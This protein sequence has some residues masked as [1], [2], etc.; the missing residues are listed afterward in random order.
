MMQSLNPVQEWEQRR[1]EANRYYQGGKFQDYLDLV[2]KNLQLARAIPDRVRE[3]Y[4]LNDLG[5][6]Y[7]GCWQPQK[8]LERFQQALCVAVEIG[9]ASAQ[10]T[11]LSNLGSTYSRLG[12]FS[13]ALEYFNQ[14]LPIF[15][16]LQDTQGE[17][18]TLN[19]VALIYTRLGEPKRAL[20][21]QN[22]ILTMR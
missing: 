17:V 13:Q 9:S 11:A 3:G 14:A 16:E 22:Q 2:T 4:T 20:L 12:R 15:R 5:L 21:L 8:A 18:S 1:D 10:A 19:D 7:L 6:A